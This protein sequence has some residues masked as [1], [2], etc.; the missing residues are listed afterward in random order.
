MGFGSGGVISI[1]SYA[2]K[3]WQ[4]LILTKE[5]NYTLAQHSGT[6]AQTYRLYQT[7]TD[8]SNYERLTLKRGSRIEIFN[9]RETAGTGADNLDILLTPAGT[10][11]VG[12]GTTSPYAKSSRCRRNGREPLHGDFN[13][14]INI[15]AILIHSCNRHIGNNHEFLFNNRILNQSLYLQ[16]FHRFSLRLPESHRRRGRDGTR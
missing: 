6:N 14:R 9:S 13:N 16:P 1:W 11:S 3:L 4:Q 8:S 7:Y 10:G 5:A 12:I 2:D 15:P